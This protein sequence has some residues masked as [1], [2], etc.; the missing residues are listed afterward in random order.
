VIVVV[1]GGRD[2][3]DVPRLWRWLDAM[4]AKHDIRHVID[5]ASDDVTGPYIGWDYWCHQWA[6]ARDRSTTRCHADWKALGRRAGPIRNQQMA[7]LK[8]D[9]CLVGPGGTGTADM[10]ARAHAAGILIVRAQ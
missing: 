3:A 7:D 10:A 1:T 4:A 9:L 5:G 6:L 2:Y 8:P